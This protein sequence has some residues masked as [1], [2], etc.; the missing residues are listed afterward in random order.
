M[1]LEKLGGEYPRIVRA[2][3]LQR[4]MTKIGPKPNMHVDQLAIVGAA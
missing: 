3:S 1:S 2:Q 4:L